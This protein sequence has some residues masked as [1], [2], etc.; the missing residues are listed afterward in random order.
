MVGYVMVEIRKILHFPADKL[1]TAGIVL[2]KAFHHD[3]I[4]NY[5]IPDTKFSI[6]LYNRNKLYY[7]QSFQKPHV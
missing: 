4:F 2:S 7:N 1:K 3:P 5:L 6:P